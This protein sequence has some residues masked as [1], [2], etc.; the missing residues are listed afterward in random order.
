MRGEVINTK[1]GEQITIAKPIGRGRLGTVFVGVHP[2]LARRFAIKVLLSRLTKDGNTL[3]RLRRMVRETSTIQHVSVIPLL[4]FGTVDDGRVYLTMDYV[5][6]MQ[7]TKVLD[8]D[9][10]L[11]VARAVPILIQLA[12]ALEAAHRLRVVHGDVKPNNIL[13]FEDHDGT[14][15]LRIYDFKLMQALSPQAT[16]EEPMGHLRLYGNFDYVAPEQISDCRVDGL[17]DIYAFGAVAYRMLTG[18]PPFFGTPEEVIRGH[19]TLDPVPPSRRVGVDDIPA[20]LEA[21]ILRCLEKK[22]EDR[23]KSMD[24]VSHLL[25]DIV[26]QAAEPQPFDDT[27]TERWEL[28]PELVPR[29]PPLPE[30]PARVRRLFYDTLLLLAD[31]VASVGQ[32]SETMIYDL[33]SLSRI[34]ESVARLM[35]ENAVTENRFEDIRRELRERESTLRY[36]IIDLNLAKADMQEQELNEQGLLELNNQISQLDRQLSDLER[37]RAQRF[38]MLNEQLQQN[39]ERLKTLEQEMAAHYQRLYSY[40][41]DSRDQVS[42]GEA[43]QLYRLLERCRNSLTQATV[44]Q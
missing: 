9:G 31:H 17:T 27:A 42:T 36:A 34:R 19:R 40:L 3:N 38:A 24:E 20:Q 14:E 33:T 10:Q 39:R 12:D 32:A 41:E 29:E 15:A 7:L 37:Q 35:A 28:P 8:R 16:S 18:E 22:P 23:F 5:R 21:I 1:V 4:D 13:L 26:P 44:T 11:H 2:V 43:R 25:R 6:G 30:S